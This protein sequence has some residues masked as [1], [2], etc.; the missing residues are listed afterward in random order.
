MGIDDMD[1]SAIES[2]KK[3][4]YT[5]FKESCGKPNGNGGGGGGFD[6]DFLALYYLDSNSISDLDFYL[7]AELDLYPDSNTITQYTMTT[8]IEEIKTLNNSYGYLPKFKNCN[9]AKE[10]SA[11]AKSHNLSIIKPSVYELIR[12]KNFLY[13]DFASIHK[14][15]RL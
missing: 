10:V 2:L 15:I 12:E 6:L 5:L 3:T 7:E 11:V 8:S 9:L 1:L 14:G 13:K 4:I